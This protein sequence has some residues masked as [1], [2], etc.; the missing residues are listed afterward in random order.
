MIAGMLRRLV[1]APQHLR[2]EFAEQVGQQQADRLRLPPAETAA[3]GIRDIPHLPCDLAHMLARPL[4]HG[5]HVVQHTGDGGNGNAGTERDFFD[6]SGHS[7]S[8]SLEIFRTCSQCTH[9]VATD[10]ASTKT[11][12]GNECPM[13][14]PLKS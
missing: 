7:R 4:V 9:A 2:E 1:A 5:I 8:V 14:N 12:D 11:R 3:H 10:L 13:E 6:G